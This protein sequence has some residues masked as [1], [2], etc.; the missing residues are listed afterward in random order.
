MNILC[1][2]I[3]SST[4]NNI[5]KEFYGTSRV[6]DRNIT[7]AELINIGTFTNEKDKF[8]ANIINAINQKEFDKEDFELRKKDSIIRIILRED[9]ML[10]L[11]GPLL[12]NI[13]T[14][15]YYHFDTVEDI[16]S[17]T[18]EDYINTINS[19]D[20]SNYCITEMIIEKD[21]QEKDD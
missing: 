16:E 7:F 6:Q 8:T 11:L 5:L 19:L 13:L 4:F 2:P 9:S 18:F 21:K 14:Y 17:F 10:N 15:D 12:D 3:S 20:Y 1:Q